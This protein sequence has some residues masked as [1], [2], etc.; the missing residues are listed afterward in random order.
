MAETEVGLDKQ[1]FVAYLMPSENGDE[2]G[3]GKVDEAEV[4]AESTGRKT[5]EYDWVREYFFRKD[6]QHTAT[7][8]FVWDSEAEAVRYN[9]IQT[10]IVLDK[11][12][13]QVRTG[14][15]SKR[16]SCPR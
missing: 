13:S 9:E 3:K 6:P 15:C 10:K 7:Y 11:I 14:P 4:E 16:L 8:F 2:K 12:K 1:S 5:E